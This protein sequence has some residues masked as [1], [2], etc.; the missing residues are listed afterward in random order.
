M[1]YHEKQVAALCGVHCLNT[2]LQGPMFSELDLASMG[3]ELD[4]LEREML[5]D[6][7]AAVAGEPG[8]MDDSGMF[9]VQVLTRALEVWQLTA[10]PAASEALRQEGFAPQREA[11]FI[12]NLLEHWFTIRRIDG[13]Y[14]NLNSLYVAPEHLSTFYLSAYL[15]SL[16]EKGWQIFVIRGPLPEPAPGELDAGAPGRWWSAEEARAAHRAAQGTR[17][18]GR[19]RNAMEAALDRA[20]AGGGAIALRTSANK[21]SA[22]FA[23]DGEE[24]DPELA[25]ALAASMQDHPGGGASSSGGLSYAAVARQAAAGGGGAGGGGAGGGGGL[26]SGGFEDD[27]PELA[28]ALAA[29]LEEHHAASQQQQEQPEQ[30]REQQQQQQEQQQREQ[31]QQQQ[32]QQ[33]EERQAAAVEVPDEPDEGAE[34]AVSLAFRLPSGDR[35]S[36]RF[37]RGETVAVAAA[38]VCRELVASGQARPGQRVELSTSFPKR[39]LPPGDELGAAGVEDRS[40]LGVAL[41][42]ATTARAS[43]CRAACRKTSQRAAEGVC[44]LMMQRLALEQAGARA[45]TAASGR[46]LA[47]PTRANRCVQRCRAAGVMELPGAA[48][49]PAAAELLARVAGGAWGGPPCAPPA[50][51]RRPA[52]TTVAGGLKK[53]TKKLAK[54]LKAHRKRL[55]SLLTTHAGGGA[56]AG[57]LQAALGELATLQRAVAGLRELQE[58]Q[59][60]AAAAAAGGDSDASSSDSEY[61]GARDERRGGAVGAAA[62]APRLGGAVVAAAALMQ[63]LEAPPIDQEQLDAVA[64]LPPPAALPG[65]GR[66]LVC[67]GKA[68]AARGGRAVL[69]AAAHAAAA[70]PGVEVVPCKCL[71]RCKAGPAVRVRSD[72]APGCTLLTEVSPRELPDVLDDAFSSSA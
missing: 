3:A 31:Q 36:R 52:T 11:G 24:D 48:P 39:A 1:I 10:T 5:G 29:S 72:A 30:E 20:E 55:E 42:R 28:A 47:P 64:A 40:V 12:C 34:G 27:D 2:L 14:W 17:A 53:E 61:G 49:A 43:S 32:Q 16:R 13:E 67:Q 26:G 22:A 54:A 50:W 46:A 35:L 38:W 69:A 15:D 63:Q 60:R 71:G 45:P 41:A 6:D 21:R 33:E 25:A 68:C 44:Q 62:G 57:A 66:V 65:A 19:A 58:E 18:Q 70:S 9:S 8:N 7:A 23:L 37:R 51:S 4:A 59:K 56:D